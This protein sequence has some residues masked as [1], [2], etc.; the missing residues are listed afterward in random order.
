M[1]KKKGLLVDK[2]VPLV[3]LWD[4]IEEIEEISSRNYIEYKIPAK[5]KNISSPGLNI[6][7]SDGQS[8]FV[9]SSISGYDEL[10]EVIHKRVHNIY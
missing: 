1:S 4:N 7:F 9:Q 8:F 2:S 5:L 6:S 3:I 10:K